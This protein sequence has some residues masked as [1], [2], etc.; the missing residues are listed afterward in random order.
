MN[1]REELLQDV[2]GK[3]GFKGSDGSGK[4]DL[5]SFYSLR[6][7]HA[8]QGKQVLTYEFN[9][10]IYKENGL[11]LIPISDVHLGSRHANIPLFQKFVNYILETPNAVTI[12]NG[13]L[14]ETATKVSVGKGH[15]EESENLPEQLDILEEILKPLADAG[16]ILGIGPGNHEERVAN[17][18]GINP[19]AILA[20]RLGVPYFGYQGFFRIVVNGITYQVVAHH[21][22]GGGGTMGSKVNSAM[23]MN[24]VI[25]NADVYISG[26]THGKLS[27]PDVVWVMDD[28]SDRLI[29]HKRTYVV[30][31]SFV[32]YFGAYPEMKALAPSITGLVMCH[33]NSQY[34]DVHT[35]V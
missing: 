29:E 33:L 22:A 13:D 7:E 14:A 35:Y 28:E 30:A 16:K 34:K 11:D 3:M 24:S 25:P 27:F 20:Q 21:G 2:L 19:M 12:L 9:E 10:D 26:H 18:I 5:S 8:P 31:G 23:K 4:K 1:S 15:F 6:R 32:E 17:M